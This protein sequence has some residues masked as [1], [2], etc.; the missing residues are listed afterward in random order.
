[1][2]AVDDSI[3][4]HAEQPGEEGNAAP[5]EAREVGERL[6]KHVRG[7]IFRLFAVADTARDEGVDTIE[8]ELIKLG[9]AAR[10]ALGGLDELPVAGRI[11]ASLQL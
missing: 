5:L 9:E 11:L 6:M 10:I 1:M 2:P 8:V 7:Q 3:G 4:G